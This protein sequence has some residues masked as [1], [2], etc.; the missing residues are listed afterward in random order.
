MKNAQTY[1][2]AYVFV[3]GTRALYDMQGNP[4]WF[5]PNIDSLSNEEIHARDL[6]LTPEGT[7][8]LV[9]HKGVYE[10]NYDGDVLWKMPKGA[11]FANDSVEFFHHEFT[12]LA[13]GHYMA[14]G[15]E[16]LR[17]AGK[18]VTGDS[19]FVLLPADN[20]RRNDK[21]RRDKISFG[22]VIEYDENNNVVWSWRS[23]DYF[24]QSDIYYRKRP[25]SIRDV[26]ENGFY[27]DEKN[28]AVYV[29]FKNLD[30]IVKVKYPEGKVTEVYGKIYK[31]GKELTTIDTGNGMFCG[32]HSCRLAEDGS[33]YLFNNN[34][35]H[36][37]YWPSVI[38]M[39]KSKG[40]KM[41]MKKTWEFECNLEALGINAQPPS[42]Y[43]VGGSV[44]E[45]S[46]HSFLVSMAGS[47]S[48]VFIVNRKKEIL[49]S[50]MCQKWN[51][52]ANHWDYVPNFHS[53]IIAGPAELER[54]IW[55]AEKI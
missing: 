23:S 24:K 40:D 5:L 11:A 44:Y 15:N 2:N 49:W 35:C 53:S 17:S 37:G 54:L 31:K 9:T 33:L 19:N 45:L 26:H 34:I 52:T 50:A 21:D 27:F 3:D 36:K 43:P 42:A 20:I 55:N 1:K 28:K 47:S 10:I 30:R 7:I 16:D 8:T 32:Q 14:M 46:D 48:N 12:R 39:K 25:V 29:S 38:M 18:S 6:K 13:N 22:T 51:A 4:V 41:G